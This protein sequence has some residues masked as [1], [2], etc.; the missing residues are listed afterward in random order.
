VGVPAEHDQRQGARWDERTTRAMLGM[1][2]VSGKRN[3]RLE[4]NFSEW[5]EDDRGSK[6]SE[7]C[8]GSTKWRLVFIFKNGS[9]YNCAELET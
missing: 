4:A 3:K 1:R 8:E 2:F 5:I 7:V 6:E 9:A